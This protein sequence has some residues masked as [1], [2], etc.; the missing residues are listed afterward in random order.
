MQGRKRK[1]PALFCF[2]RGRFRT[3]SAAGGQT[4]RH[5]V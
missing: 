3:D 5:Q 2:C 4:G 1:L